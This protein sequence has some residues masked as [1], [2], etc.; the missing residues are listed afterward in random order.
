[1]GAPAPA[2][3]RYSSRPA[4]ASGQ[5]SLFGESPAPVIQVKT[6]ATTLNVSVVNTPEKLEKLS[7]ALSAA[8][9]IAFDTETTS[10]EEMQ[11]EVVGISIATETGSGWYI[12]V[13]HQGGQNLPLAQILAALK[14][15]LTN[16]NIPKIGHNLKYDTLMLA[17][18]GLRVTP[19]AFDTMIAEWLIDPGSHNLGLKAL[20]LA[21]LGLEMTHIEALIGKGKAQISMV[22]VPVEA[23]APYAVA[24]AET[25]LQLK[26]LLEAELRRV[27]L[28]DVLATVEMPLIAVLAEMEMAGVRLDLDFFRRFSTEINA[29]ILEVESQIFALVGE[30]FNLNSTQQL[31]KILF[32]RLHLM[33][34]NRG[35]KTQSGHYSTSADVLDELRGQHAVVDLVLEY[36]ELSKLKSTYVESLPLAVDKNTG[37]VHTSYNQIGSVT[38]RLSSSNPNLQNIPTRT[39]MGRRVRNGF[40]A[41][42]GNVLLSVDYSQIEL[43]IVAHVAGDAAMLEA[44]RQGRDIHATTAAKIFG[45]PLEQVTKEQRRHAKAINFGLI[46]GMSAFG[47]TRSTELTLGES[48]N[49]V[50][51]YFQEFPGVK[52]YLDETRKLAHE[53]GYVETLLGRR[54]YFPLLKSPIN[55]N[56]RNREERE[57]INA[58]IQGTAADIMKIAMLKVPTALQAAGLSGKMLLQVHDEIVIECPEQELDRTAKTVQQTMANA[59]P[60]SI[61]LCTEAR[62][63]LRWG[64]MKV[65]QN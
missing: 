5:M 49:F 24:D 9:E 30:T 61:P 50:K 2:T 1:M 19:L 47:L 28:L 8:R 17:R 10:T 34:P 37:R 63:G 43:R 51:A 25:C 42:A 11:A 16:P 48:E 33:P 38:G 52:R 15:P 40:I 21:R 31:S 14:N 65:M 62:S 35:R 56:L 64:E 54:R 12:P 3:T 45:I 46:Y 32:E 58:P 59:Y 13:G 36:R 44:F 39:E 7:A 29:R 41:E 57:A 53:Q 22:Q 27:N 55:A 18:N 60:L 23:A 26:P 6:P 20:A 4:I